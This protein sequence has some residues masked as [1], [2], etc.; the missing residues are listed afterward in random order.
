[1]Y[2]SRKDVESSSDGLATFLAIA[3]DVKSRPL[4][5]GSVSCKFHVGHVNC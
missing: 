3:C 4:C 5:T 1:M 2:A